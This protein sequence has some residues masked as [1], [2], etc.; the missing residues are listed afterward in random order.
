MAHSW[1]VQQELLG[2]VYREIYDSDVPTF[3]LRPCAS[4][5]LE[6]IHAAFDAD[7][8]SARE[9]SRL[10]DHTLGCSLSPDAEGARKERR[11]A[12][13]VLPF[14]DKPSASK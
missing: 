13:N 7:I 10:M 12:A 4:V 3:V 6:G 9:A 11:A 14:R 1:G 2:G 8:L 5:P